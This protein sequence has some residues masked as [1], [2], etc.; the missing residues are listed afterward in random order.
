MK[1]NYRNALNALTKLGVPTY[2]RYDM[3]H[4]AISAEDSESYKFCDYYDG[5]RIPDWEFGVSP[6]VTETLRK[7]GLHAEWINPGELGVYED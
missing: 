6:V 1:R 5:Y 7:Y 3:E 4:F 2:Q